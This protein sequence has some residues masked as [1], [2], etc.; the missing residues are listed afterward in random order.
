MNK[1][2]Q[3]KMVSKH[4]NDKRYKREKFIAEDLKGDGKVIDSFIIDKRHY[5]GVERHDVTDNGIVL[6]YNVESGKLIT[7]LIASSRQ[8]KRYYKDSDKD[9]PSWLV[10]L[11][12][13]RE[14]LNYNYI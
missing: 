3:R 8:I 4:Y 12:E 13:W 10:R 5:K 11:C 1:N 6:I 14:S 7:K 9:P 2:N